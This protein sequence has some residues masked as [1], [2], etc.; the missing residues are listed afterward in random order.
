MDL[1]LSTS[2]IPQA[3]GQVSAKEAKTTEAA[4]SLQNAISR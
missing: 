4:P 3:M 1:S 2:S